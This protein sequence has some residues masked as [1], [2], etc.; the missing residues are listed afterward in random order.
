MDIRL[1]FLLAFAC[2]LLSTRIIMP[3]LLRLC[4]KK[5]LFDQPGERKVHSARIPRLGGAIFIPT[6]ALGLTVSLC[7]LVSNNTLIETFHFNT[8]IV[9]MGIL[10]IYMIGMLDDLFGLSANLK[11]VVQF[12]AALCFPLSGL[13]L[14]NLYGFCGLWELSPLVGQAFTVFVVMFIVNSINT[15]DGIDGLCSGLCCIGLA[16]Y[17]YYFYDIQ[18]NVFCLFTCS[19]IGT[20]L[21]FMYYNLFGNA[22]KGT[23][24]FM[25]DSGSLMLGFSLS[26]LG[27]KLSMTNITIAPPAEGILIPFTVLIIPTFDLIRVATNRILRGVHPFSPDKTHIHHLLLGFGLSQHKALLTLLISDVLLIALN[28]SLWHCGLGLTWIVAIDI[29]L[30]A[31]SV[32]YLRY[33]MPK[34][35]YIPAS[36]TTNSIIQ[37]RHA[38]T[39]TKSQTGKNVRSKTAKHINRNQPLISIIVATY[40][41][42]KTLSDTL[43]SIL[44]QTYKNYEVVLQDGASTDETMSVVDRY[45]ELFGDRISIVSEKDEGLYDAMNKAIDRAKG[46]I[47]GILNSDDF[48]TSD[49]V[50][51]RI[52]EEFKKNPLLEAVYGDIHYVNPDNLGKCV[53]YYS[54]RAFRPRYMRIGLMPAHPS[55]YCLRSLYEKY[56]KFD[57][58]FKVAAD[59]DQLFRL[60]YMNRIRAFYIP[61]DFVTM[62]TGGASTSGIK[63]HLQIMQDHLEAIRSQGVYANRWILATRYIYKVF[64]IISSRIASK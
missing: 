23:K 60:I 24:T 46:D 8:I 7:M 22:Q 39:A 13:Y 4:H 44:K 1:Y 25:G 50:L 16:V 41:S 20:L 21:V 17:T 43:D 33:H 14:N 11:F 6:T 49:D 54:S 55:F 48:Y 32:E 18:N 63:S 34:D 47:V 9:G 64:E 31:L 35:F 36:K 15:I 52:V 61:M 59:F 27:L 42:S 26:Y 19:L 45:K 51:K 29:L 5:N 53:R 56:G 58:R 3:W 57:T 10:I 38:A 28:L 30:F 40:N 37:T 62:R 12:I 2:S